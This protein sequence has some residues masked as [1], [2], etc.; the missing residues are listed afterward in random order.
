M[1]TVNFR[2]FF[3]KT[4]VPSIG[5]DPE[6]C[7]PGTVDGDR[8]VGYINDAMVE[9]MHYA[10]WPELMV[11]EERELDS[12]N[13]LPWSA[14]GKTDI[15]TVEGIFE[16]EANAI[17]PRG[18]LWFE[19]GPA[20]FR[21]FDR[22]G[23]VWVRLRPYPS[24]FSRTP[25]DGDAVD[26]NAVFYDEESGNCFRSLIDNNEDEPTAESENWERVEFPEEFVP[27][28]KAKAAAAHLDDE[29]KFDAAGS[30]EAQANKIL[31][32]LKKSK[33]L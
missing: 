7:Q 24:V 16:T 4:F 1:R 25:W 21:V 15:D 20:G 10:F 3:E 17:A 12:D 9:A 33:G 11:I 23:T 28:V 32:N 18:H 29:R 27:Y 2:T 13:I 14:E 22:T 5:K 30:K 6:N 8:F 19:Q 31:F 26:T